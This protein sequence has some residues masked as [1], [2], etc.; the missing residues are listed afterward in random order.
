MTFPVGPRPDC[1]SQCLSSH[2]CIVFKN[3]PR[4]F[5]EGSTVESLTPRVTCEVRFGE[6][7][8]K[9]TIF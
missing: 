3:E 7:I 6:F 2:V 9:E 8:T 5:V 4:I 1:F